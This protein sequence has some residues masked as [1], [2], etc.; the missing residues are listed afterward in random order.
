[1][2]VLIQIARFVIRMIVVGAGLFLDRLVAMT[3]LVEI[4]RRMAGVIV[5]LTRFFLGHA[6]LRHSCGPE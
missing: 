1:M 3:M 5:M 4:T 2:P 6:F